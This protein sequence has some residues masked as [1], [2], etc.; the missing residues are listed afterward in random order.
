MYFCCSLFVHFLV[1][2]FRLFFTCGLCISAF[3]VFFPSA[4]AFLLFCCCSFILCFAL[5]VFLSLLLSFVRCFILHT[6]LLSS[7]FISVVVY[8]IVRYLS[9]VSSLFMCVLLAFFLSCLC[10][11]VCFLVC[12][13]I[14]SFLAFMCSLFCCSVFLPSFLHVSLFRYFYMSVFVISFLVTFVVYLFLFIVIAFRCCFPT[15]QLTQHGIW[16][17]VLGKCSLDPQITGERFGTKGLWT[18]SGKPE[19]P[20][21]S[22]RFG[23]VRLKPPAKSQENDGTPKLRN[24]R[25]PDIKGDHLLTP[26]KMEP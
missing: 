13:L 9:F 24:S 11:F 19:G 20:F 14:Y 16:L 3:L 21:R 1:Y 7:T 23:Q 4:S 22:I 5:S 26:L 25:G 12:F 17:L 6:Y 2:L 8:L 18:K 10:L 15:N